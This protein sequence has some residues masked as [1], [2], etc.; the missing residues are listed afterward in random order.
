MEFQRITPLHTPIKISNPAKLKM[1]VQN[2]YEL[3]DLL[4]KDWECFQRMRQAMKV[5]PADQLFSEID[6]F[7][8]GYFDGYSLM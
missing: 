4:E 8:N 5:L 3:E 7:G 2:R 1:E 6:F